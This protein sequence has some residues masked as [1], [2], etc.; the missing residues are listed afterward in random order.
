MVYS[1]VLAAQMVVGSSPEPSP[2][3]VDMSASMSIEKAQLQYWP[4]YSQ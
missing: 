1:T 2:M 3:L 4:P